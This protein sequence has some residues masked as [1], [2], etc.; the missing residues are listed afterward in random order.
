MGM[1]L[2]QVNTLFAKYV[3]QLTDLH[4]QC[5][6]CDEMPAFNKGYWWIVYDGD[7]P[8]GFCGL[9]HVTSWDA[10]GYLSRGG[11][12]DEYRGKGLQRRMINV[13]VQKAR[14]VGWNWLI[15]ATR[16]N[17]PSSNN[18]ISCG[19]KMYAPQ[20]EWL[21]GHSLYWIRKV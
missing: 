5:F 20:H 9:T 6:P 17:I 12:I 10:A 2:K 8:I 4:K 15:S 18:L 3:N 7:L 19:F 21:D 11:V 16:D 1:R 14:K 13:R